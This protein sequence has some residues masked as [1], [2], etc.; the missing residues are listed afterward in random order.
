MIRS[1]RIRPLRA[2]AAGAAAMLV[3][4][5]LTAPPARAAEKDVPVAVGVRLSSLASPATGGREDTSLLTVELGG[6]DGAQVEYLDAGAVA[7]TAT[8]PEMAGALTAPAGRDVVAAANGDFFDIGATGAPRGA[9]MRDGEALKS[10][11]GDRVE[12]AVFGEDGTGRIGT[13]RFEGTADL[14][15]GEVGLDALNA[16]VV[17]DGGLGLYTPEWGDRSRK[18]AAKGAKRVAEAVVAGDV[19]REVRDGAGGGAIEEGTEVLVGLGKAADRV[20]GLEK[21][22]AVSVDYRLDAGGPARTVIGG[23]RVLVRDGAPTGA[24][25]GARHPRTAIGFS[26]DGRRMFLAAVD[27]RISGVP[28]A[29]LPEVARMLADAGADQALELDGGGSS[30]L[31]A[32]SPG[33]DGLKKR[34]RNGG[35]RER[36]VPNGLAVT[37]VSGDALAAGPGPVPPPRALPRSGGP[38]AADAPRVPA[39]AAR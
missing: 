7:A 27:G 21:G 35:D 5:S 33:K 6:E 1:A 17:P 29:T 34:N 22:D 14:P 16:H 26:A 10:P 37:A 18:G 28:G 13:V 36:P 25:D 30:A 4:S 19:V 8:V 38:L 31:L 15:S 20:A 24:S 11:T 2:V 32:R 3:A 39:P 9:A 12:A 23:H